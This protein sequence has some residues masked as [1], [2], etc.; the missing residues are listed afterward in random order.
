MEKTLEEK[1]RLLDIENLMFIFFIIASLIDIMANEKSRELLLNNNDLNEELRKEYLFASYLI[2]FVFIIFMERNYN[3]LMM[4]DEDDEEY[5]FAKIR[6]FGSMLIV[7]G[8]LYVIY[9]YMNT[10]LFK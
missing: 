3:N 9:F 4:L 7:L 6:L 10:S 5:K 8:Q 2:L 1:L